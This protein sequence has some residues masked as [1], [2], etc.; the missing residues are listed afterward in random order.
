M[1][2]NIIPIIPITE[3]EKNREDNFLHVCLVIFYQ[4]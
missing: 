2:C 4:M 1:K 3:E